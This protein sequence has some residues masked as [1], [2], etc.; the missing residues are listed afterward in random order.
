M[1]YHD[2]LPVIQSR[3]LDEA[4][5]TS[6]QEVQCSDV[7]M[8]SNVDSAVTALSTDEETIV[9]KIQELEEVCNVHSQQLKLYEKDSVDGAYSFA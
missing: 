1:S 6:W 9:E 5:E 3:R 7:D 4:S 8:E 2:V